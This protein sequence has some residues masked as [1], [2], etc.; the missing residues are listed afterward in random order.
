MKKLGPWIGAILVVG[1]VLV[2]QQHR[3]LP[4]IVLLETGVL[5]I[6]VVL[7]IFHLISLWRNRR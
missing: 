1:G 2:Y 5:G 7:G 6:A 3:H 4:A